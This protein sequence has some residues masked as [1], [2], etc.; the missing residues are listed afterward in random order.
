MKNWICH[1]QLIGILCAILFLVAGCK[2]ECNKITKYS[3]E[4]K[5]VASYRISD[6][7]QVE[8]TEYFENGNVQKV[9]ELDG[10]EVSGFY[11]EFFLNGE[12]KADQ[13]VIDTRVGALLPTPEIN[14][15]PTNFG[16]DTIDAGTDY[17]FRVTWKN[18]R[19]DQTFLMCD[20]CDELF[21]LPNSTTYTH[22]FKKMEPGEL[23]IFADVYGDTGLVPLKKMKLIVR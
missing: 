7:G 11:K 9:Y 12:V 6:N 15:V 21:Y 19:P 5:M 22:I 10:L 17:Y 23:E 2:N 13:P 4:G 20:G 18:T 1:Y 3:K 16:G 8:A 14:L